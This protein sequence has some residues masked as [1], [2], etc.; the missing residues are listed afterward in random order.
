MLQNFVVQ[1]NDLI[2]RRLYDQYSLT[3]CCTQVTFVALLTHGVRA[4]PRGLLVRF[5]SGLSWPS[6]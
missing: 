6:N 3:P 1:A 2:S 4:R 5:S